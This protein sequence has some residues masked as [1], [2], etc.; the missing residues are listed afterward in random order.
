MTGVEDRGDVVITSG[1]VQQRANF[2]HRS[3]CL[4]STQHRSRC[5]SLRCICGFMQNLSASFETES[6]AESVQK[7]AERPEEK[8]SLHLRKAQKRA[9]LPCVWCVIGVWGQDEQPPWS[10]LL[11]RLQ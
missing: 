4:L 5:C 1:S 8:E 7:L 11:W 10:G 9:R 2:H 3:G 6:K